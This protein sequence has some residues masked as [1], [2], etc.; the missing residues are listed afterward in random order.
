M[1]FRSIF[2]A[3]L[4]FFVLLNL[5]ALGIHTVMKD[6]TLGVDYVCFWNAGRALWLDHLTPYS[7][8]IIQQNQIMIYRRLAKPDEDQFVF[9]YPIYSLLIMLPFSW[10]PIDWSQSFWLAFTLLLLF[11]IFY[12]SFSS[13]LKRIIFSYPLFLPVFLGLVVGNFNIPVSLF[14]ILILSFLFTGRI[15][16]RGIQILSGILLAWATIKPQFIWAYLLFILLYIIKQKYWAAFISFIS[17][18]VVFV[19]GMM[20]IRPGWIG[21]WL[22]F[23]VKNDNYTKGVPTINYVLSAF[24]SPPLLNYIVPVI[25]FIFF[26]LSV[27]LAWK[28]WKGKVNLFSMIIWC[29]FITYLVHPSHFY[30]EQIIFL[31]PILFW[32]ASRKRFSLSLGIVWVGG[33]LL[34]W[35]FFLLTRSNILPTN[36]IYFPFFLFIFWS[37]WYVIKSKNSNQT[38]SPG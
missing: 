30:C 15:R 31:I 26:I 8:E 25:L 18:F 28:W 2:L 36:N 11:S 16:A 22:Q 9:A 3:V 35:I 17:S 23:V 32:A 13:S 38:I 27:I 21:E 1:K 29:G 10:M 6:N 7:D 37:V 4:L 12:Y 19:G 33:I 5:F 34:S 24:F 20:V 14:L